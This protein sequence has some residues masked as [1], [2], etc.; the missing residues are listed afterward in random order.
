MNDYKDALLKSLQEPATH[1]PAWSIQD[2][3]SRPLADVRPLADTPLSK[4]SVEAAESFPFPIPHGSTYA[5]L[6]T[7]TVDVMNRCAAAGWPL[8]RTLSM[9]EHIVSQFEGAPA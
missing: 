1:A 9:V 8:D 7:L 4:A 6:H 3:I 5:S 2:M